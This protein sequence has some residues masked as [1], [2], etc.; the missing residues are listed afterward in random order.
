MQKF[1]N[2]VTFTVTPNLHNHCTNE[3]TSMQHNITTDDLTLIM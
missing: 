3:E 1:A 2:Y